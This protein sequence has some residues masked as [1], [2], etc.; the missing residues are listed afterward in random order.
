M[1]KAD[2]IEALAKKEGLMEKEATPS[3]T[4]SLMVS[5]ILSIKA[6]ESSLDRLGS[7]Q[8]GDEPRFPD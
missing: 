2:L 8:T 6:A 4:S 7:R 1:N 3:S 5:P